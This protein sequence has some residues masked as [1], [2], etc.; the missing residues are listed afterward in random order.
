MSLFKRAGLRWYGVWWLTGWAWV[1]LVWYLSLTSHPID[2]DLGTTF[3]DKIGHATAYA[4]LMVWFGNLY[5]CRHG[6]ISYGIIFVAMGILLE[7][8]Q[9]SLT[10]VRQFSYG[11]ML[12]NSVGVLIGYMLLYTFPAR[13]LGKLESVFGK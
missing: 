11:D 5:Q 8:L 12:A 2:I 13:M 3:N 10:S 7:V 9:G 6:R 1:I 4:W